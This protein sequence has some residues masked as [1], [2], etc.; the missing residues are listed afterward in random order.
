V[1]NAMGACRWSS[2]G[3]KSWPELQQ[4]HLRANLLTGSLPA[5]WGDGGSMPALR[6][7]TVSGNRLSGPIPSSWDQNGTHPRFPFLQAVMLLPGARPCWTI[8]KPQ[9][10]CL[11]RPLICSLSTSPLWLRSRSAGLPHEC[12]GAS[13]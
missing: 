13:C 11:P 10:A 7:F 8:S 3:S 4:L 2:G 5:S 6:N 1:T 9:T 12:T